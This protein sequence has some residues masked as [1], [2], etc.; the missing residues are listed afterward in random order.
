MV[1]TTGVAANAYTSSFMQ[2]TSKLKN[3]EYTTVYLSKQLIEGH[4]DQTQQIIKQFMHMFL[5]QMMAYLE[6]F[7]TLVRTVHNN[8][9]LVIQDIMLTK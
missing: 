3:L 6:L 9:D 2:M 1:S 7:H 4:E 5:K 8:Q